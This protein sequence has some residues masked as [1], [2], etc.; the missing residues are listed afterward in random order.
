MNETELDTLEQVEKFLSGTETVSFQFVSKDERY[1]WLQQRLV[2]FRYRG[3]NKAEKGL[4]RR[5]LSKVSGYSRQQLTRLIKQY[6]N[7]GKLKRDQRTVNGF[8][9]RYTGED[10]ALLAQLDELH[11]TLSGPATKKLCE[12]AYQVF[13]QPQ[14]ERLAGISV[15]HL[16]NLRKSNAYTRRRYTYEKTRA[17]RS[18]T[19]GER[20][21]PQPQGQPGYIRVDTV[22]Q[23]DLDKHKGV[24]HINAVDEITQFELISSVE[25]I[26][27]AYLLSALAYLLDTF[28]FVILGFHSDNGSEYV[29]KTVATLLNKLLIEFTKS[30][31]RQSN[32]N[33]LVESKNGAVVRKHWGYAHIPQRYAQQLNDFN[34]HYLNPYLNF[35][36][37]CLFAVTITDAK[38]KQR[39]TYPYSQMMTPYD[40]LKSLPEASQYLK[41]EISFAQLDEIAYQISDNEAARQLQ[42]ARQKLFKSITE[43]ESRAA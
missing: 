24:Y 4:L 13:G 3:L 1:E 37:P 20:R 41:P 5:Y 21:K 30:R 25:R 12:R 40:K 34:H 7:H 22:H 29:N 33:A 9:C 42:Q 26:S 11:A 31:P 15:S 35:H 23:G 14:Y 19:I 16:Y 27:E 39:K 8:Q 43:Q 17:T 18:A 2:H 36:R 6:R 10:I 32:D 38:G 28:P